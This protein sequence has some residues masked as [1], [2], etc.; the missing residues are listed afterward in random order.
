MT[1]ANS[2]GAMQNMKAC[3][4]DDIGS[5]VLLSLK[6]KIWAGNYI[7]LA[8]LTNGS[9]ELQQFA[10]GSSVVLNEREELEAKPKVLNEKIATINRW[11]GAFLIFL[12]VYIQR[13]SGRAAEVVQYLFIIRDAA[14]RFP[15][16]AG[17]ILTSS[18][19]FVKQFLFRVGKN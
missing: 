12:H 9:A 14:G 1:S 8:L 10:A 19:E 13:H 17:E 7:N 3:A 4:W 15:D 11:T 16:R 6:Q 2:L 18:L 5:H